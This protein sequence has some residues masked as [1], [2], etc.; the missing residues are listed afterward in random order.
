MQGIIEAYDK[1]IERRKQEIRTL[2]SLREQAR[3]SFAH[4]LNSGN[5]TLSAMSISV[6]IRPQQFKDMRQGEATIEYLIRKGKE[7]TYPEL[8]EV[9]SRG[10][11][12]KHLNDKKGGG[13]KK[14][15]KMNP[16]L[17]E[18]DGLVYLKEWL[19]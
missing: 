12:E 5:A 7:A 19:D 14:S 16:R 3:T 6:D 13:I 8:E 15:V 9:L 2:E 1:E 4:E 10:G 18:Q 11:C 17:V